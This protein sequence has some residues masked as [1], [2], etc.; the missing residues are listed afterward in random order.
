LLVF[1]N[2]PM[3][4]VVKKMNRWYNVN[5]VIKDNRLKDYNYTATFSDEKLDEVLK[6]FQHTSPIIVEAVGREME[7][8]GTYSK[9]TIELSFYPDNYN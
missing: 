9:R 5:I 2:E 7:P 6:I 1:R 8:D 3:E 4:N